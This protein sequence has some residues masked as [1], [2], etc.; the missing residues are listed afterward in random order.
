MY[1]E[2]NL[3]DWYIH[4]YIEREGE[5]FGSGIC[6]SK[7]AVEEINIPPPRP[8]SPDYYEN[9]LDFPDPSKL[10]HELDKHTPLSEDVKNIVLSYG[11]DPREEF[12]NILHDFLE[13]APFTAM[14]K[15]HNYHNLPAIRRLKALNRR[16][17]D[18]PHFSL[19]PI[20]RY[21]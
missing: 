16:Y 10:K 20:A 17:R 19:E 8:P 3:A 1:H 4:P 11:E 6:S 13:F 12:N 7:T 5:I 14:R 15:K 2:K 18:D 9:A 21:L